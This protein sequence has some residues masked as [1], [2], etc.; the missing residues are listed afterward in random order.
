MIDML[1]AETHMCFIPSLPSSKRSS[2]IQW[3]GRKEEGE[4][5][6]QKSKEWTKWEWLLFARESLAV[7]ISGILTVTGNYL[8]PP[9]GG[10]AKA[11]Q[12]EIRP[13][14]AVGVL[15][16][17][18]GRLAGFGGP[19]LVSRGWW[20]GC[21]LW[22]TL[23]PSELRDTDSDAG[24]LLLIRNKGKGN[25]LP[26]LPKCSCILQRAQ[27]SRGQPSLQRGLPNWGILFLSNTW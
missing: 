7:R 18:A 17:G 27:T 26:P 22:R 4:E 8:L 3:L 6:G 24:S 2:S 11:E 9:S 20:R 25:L 23:G 21:I 14:W 16:L 1:Y 19:V 12:A 15:C 13:G 10:M 5:G